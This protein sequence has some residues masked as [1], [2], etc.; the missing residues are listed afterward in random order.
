MFSLIYD[1]LKIKSIRGEF[2]MSLRRER[3]HRIIDNLSDE[4]LER[5]YRELVNFIKNDEDE[6]FKK[7]FDYVIKHYDQTLKNLGDE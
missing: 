5:V 3:L 2:T 1:N 4:Q 6:E 7:A